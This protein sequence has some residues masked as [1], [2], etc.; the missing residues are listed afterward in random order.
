MGKDEKSLKHERKEVRA[1]ESEKVKK[2]YEV[3]IKVTKGRRKTGGEEGERVK[4]ENNTVEKLRK[5][6]KGRKEQG[7]IGK[8]VE[9]GGKEGEKGNARTHIA[10]NGRRSFEKFRARNSK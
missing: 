4:E 9:I 5:D 6:R 2:E 7:G 10:S 3:M 1:E 8:K